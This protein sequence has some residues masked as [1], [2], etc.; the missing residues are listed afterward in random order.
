M[1]GITTSCRWIGTKLSRSVVTMWIRVNASASSEVLR[2]SPIVTKR[3]QAGRWY[4]TEDSRPNAMLRVSSTSATSPVALVRYHSGVDD[5]TTMAAGGR[6]WGAAGAPA[7]A[8]AAAD[9]GLT[10]GP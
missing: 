4:L 5:V 1:N 7:R 9:T 6:T 8:P 3:G 2:C 10:A